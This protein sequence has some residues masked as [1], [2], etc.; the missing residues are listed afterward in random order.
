MWVGS[1]NLEKNRQHN[2]K[3]CISV[4]LQPGEFCKLFFNVWVRFIIFRYK[5]FFL[6]FLLFDSVHPFANNHTTFDFAWVK[7]A[8]FIQP[9]IALHA[10]NTNLF[11]ISLFF[12]L[13]TLSTFNVIEFQTDTASMNYK[14]KT[15][16][17]ICWMIINNFGDWDDWSWYSITFFTHLI[18]PSCHSLTVVDNFTVNF[19]LPVWMRF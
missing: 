8:W 5:S 10:L 9:P 13:H 17:T 1:I 2:F 12:R 4:L 11:R 6:T 19:Q 15:F 3:I 16:I 7:R 14:T 18:S